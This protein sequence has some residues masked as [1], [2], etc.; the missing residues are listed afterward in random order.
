M[1]ATKDL[2]VRRSS[3]HG[4]ARTSTEYHGSIYLANNKGVV[5]PAF[6]GFPYHTVDSVASAPG[7][8][9]SFADQLNWSPRGA[10]LPLIVDL[11]AIFG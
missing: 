3:R 9:R 4:I 6:R 8:S 7:N 11:A 5:L 1:S 10:R 2:L